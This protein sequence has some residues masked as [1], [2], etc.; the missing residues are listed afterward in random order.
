MFMPVGCFTIKPFHS[1]EQQQACCCT[2]ITCRAQWEK[3][4]NLPN[5][6]AAAHHDVPDYLNHLGAFHLW[7]AAMRNPAFLWFMYSCFRN[8]FCLALPAIPVLNSISST[9]SILSSRYHSTWMAR[10][11]PAWSFL[12]GNTYGHESESHCG[13]WYAQIL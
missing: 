11:G 3:G 5:F 8:I 9:L 2:H 1:T 4:Q 6:K 12:G 7:S 10:L 13:R